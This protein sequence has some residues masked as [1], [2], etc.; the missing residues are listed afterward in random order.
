MKKILVIISAPRSGSTHLCEL[1]RNISSLRVY[2]EIF[3]PGAAYGFENH[4]SQLE[5]L[6]KFLE[7]EFKSYSDNRLTC[8][9]RN[10][11]GSFLE[12]E[13]SSLLGASDAMCFKIFPGHL[14]T[15]VFQDE[16][17]RRKDVF[18]LFLQRRPVDAYISDL[19]ASHLGTYNNA[20]T[21]NL[22]I[23]IS[24]DHFEAWY[25]LRNKWFYENYNFLSQENLPYADLS[26]EIDIAGE[27]SIITRDLVK[28][29][30]RHGFSF[31]IPRHLINNSLQKQDL[32]TDYSKKVRD[33][34][35]FLNRI[36]NNNKQI[37]LYK[38][39]CPE[40]RKVF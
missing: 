35:L 14:E 28:G 27:P 38:F 15:K 8:W 33:W 17:L 26:Y 31:E 1:L 40:M 25:E 29:F 19:K 9:L 18:V 4:L 11:P 39:F 7:V 10:N 22:A 23:D 3:H 13:S 2:T 5:K 36:F 20:D 6:S 34:D 16:I 24:E 12:Y 37:R 21:T 32:E 30:G